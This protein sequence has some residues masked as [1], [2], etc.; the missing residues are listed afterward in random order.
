KTGEFAH[1]SNERNRGHVSDEGVILR[2][3]ADDGADLIEVFLDIEAEDACGPTGRLVESEEGVDEGGLACAVGTEQANRP[4]GQST[5]EVVKN[6][7]RSEVYVESGQFDC[8][9]HL[10]WVFRSASWE[11]HREA[12][13]ADR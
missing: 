10:N 2:H 12:R 5:R 4:A 6:L 3:E 1:H 8:R 13:F 11:G 9:G 7:A